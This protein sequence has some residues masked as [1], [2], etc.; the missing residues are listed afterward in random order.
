MGQENFDECDTPSLTEVLA[1]RNGEPAYEPM[2]RDPSVDI[3]QVVHSL[4][5]GELMESLGFVSVGP[6]LNLR[7]CED[8]CV[9]TGELWFASIQIRTALPPPWDENS[10]ADDFVVSADFKNVLL[11]DPAKLN[12]INRR[13]PGLN[14]SMNESGSVSV[15]TVQTLIGG[16]V[17]ENLLWALIRFFHDAERAY[18]D[19]TV[20]Y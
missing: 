4:S 18:K 6:T 2:Q 11:N 20:F 9:V 5:P 3:H 13:Y 14:I 17:L 8:K 10:A 1:R 16:R 7:Y 19:L 12:E 15:A